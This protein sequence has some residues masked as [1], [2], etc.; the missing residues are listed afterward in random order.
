MNLAKQIIQDAEGATKTIEV[1]VSSANSY[2]DAKK[3]A[4]SVLIL[5]WL[6]QQ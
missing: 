5:L 2:E 6:K 3:I 4:K 1:N